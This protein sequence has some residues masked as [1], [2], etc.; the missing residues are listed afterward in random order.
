MVA[1]R[2]VVVK[3]VDVQ[4]KVAAVAV[5]GVVVRVVKARGDV[6]VEVA[7]AAA[8]AAGATRI[9]MLRLL[10]RVLQQH[11]DCPC[12]VIRVLLR[13]DVECTRWAQNL[14]EFCQKRENSACS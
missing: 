3:A 6:G 5:T 12:Q 2:V 10:K 14:C 11:D 8:A 7:A 13:Q 1:V 4:A 9:A